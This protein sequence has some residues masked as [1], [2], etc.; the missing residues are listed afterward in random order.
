MKNIQD[1]FYNSI[2]PEASKGSIDCF[3]YY[4]ICFNTKV[5]GEIIGAHNPLYDDVPLLEINNKEEFDELLYEY[6]KVALDFYSDD[7]FFD[8]VLSGEYRTEENK[9]CKE[10]VLMTLLWGNA[11]IED[12]EDP[13]RFLR[14]QKAYL[15]KDFL[16]E[17]E[18]IG[19][20]RVLDSN[21][22]TSVTKTNQLSL[23]SPYAFHSEIANDIEIFDLPIV[24]FG[25]VN[26]IVYIY[27]I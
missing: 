13:C 6:I 19:Y 18:C 3:M 26:D 7:F 24:R 20:S 25:V 8:E 5:E 9:L 14:R 22:F 10:K 16:K 15:E 11:T 27:S 2:V 12:F 1:I 23:E 17:K 4:H 21:I